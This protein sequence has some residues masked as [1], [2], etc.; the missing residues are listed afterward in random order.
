[1]IAEGER[2]GK[3][4]MGVWGQRCKLLYIEWIKQQQGPGQH[5][6]LYSASCDKPQWKECKKEVHMGIT[7]SLCCTAEN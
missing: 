3:E 1:M 6:A 4:G 5:R 7:E 2:V